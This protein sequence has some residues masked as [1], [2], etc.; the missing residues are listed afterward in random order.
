MATGDGRRAVVVGGSLTGL[1]AAAALARHC[2]RVTLVERDALAAGPEARKGVPQARHVHVLLKEG[3]RILADLFP[4]LVAELVA[5]GAT[6]VDMARDTHWFYFGAWKARFASGVEF[7]SQSR[8]FLEWRV[9]Q[10]LAAL[11]NVT[12]RPET[13]VRG[14]VLD[15]ARRVR[16]VRVTGADRLDADL[17]VDATGRVS[18]A[19]AWLADAGLAPPRES[20]VTVGVGYASRFYRRPAGGLGDWKALF[21][22]PRPPGTRLGVMVPVEDDRWMVTLVGWFGDHPPDDEAG[23]RAFAASLP[24]P[25]F[26]AALEGAEPLSPIVLHK[27]PA[28]LRRHYE[29]L[30]TMPDGLAV[31]GDALCSFNPIYG[32]GM[33]TGAIG[34]RTLDL[35]LA[36]RRGRDLAGFS[37]SF[38]RRLAAAIDSPWLLTTCED[39]RSAAAEGERPAWM[40]LLHWYTRRVQ[41]LTWHDQLVGKRFLEVMHL[42]K[43]PR[44]LFHPAILWR[45]LTSGAG[46]PPAIPAAREAA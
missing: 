8:S 35:A 40:P 34:A 28:N 18:R 4:G 1:M 27:F 21:V 6:V 12:L 3:E 5:A 22:Y 30:P 9:R 37:R 36:E 44:T 43:P 24:V 2:A 17:V 32:Q 26:A 29:D 33:T 25:D 14:L 39:L 10:R 19:T 16:G 31:I 11:P 7:L 15:E 23:F 45:V 41:Q 20:R 38:Q 13:E 46:A 42:L